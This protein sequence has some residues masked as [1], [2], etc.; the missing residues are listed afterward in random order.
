L[1]YKLRLCFKDRMGI[2]ADISTILASSGFNIVSMDVDRSK[3]ETHV[4]TEIENIELLIDQHGLFHIFD[5]IENFIEIQFIDTL[6]QEEKANRF[7]VVLDNMSDGVISID[8]DGTITTM[9]KV[10]AEVFMCNSEN[11][12]GQSIK[13]LNLPQYEI[14]KC[15]RGDKIDNI[16]QNLITANGRYQYLSTCKPIRDSSGR[17][18]GAVEIAKEMQEIKKLARSISLEMDAISFSDIIGENQAIK[19]AIAFAQKIAPTD[20]TVSIYGPSGTGKELFAKAIHTASNRKGLYIPVNCAA[21]PEQLLESELFGYVGGAFTG[22][23]KEGRAGLFEA[24]MDGTV[25]LDE[26]AEMPLGSQAKL[27]RLIQ[28]MAVRRIGDSKEIPINTRLITATNKNLD[29]LVRQNKFREDLYYRINVI[30]IHIPTLKERK[31][32]IPILL[33]HFL[34]EL[35]IRLG[36]KISSI[37]PLALQK[38]ISYDWPGNVRELKNVVERAAFFSNDTVIDVDAILFSHELTPYHGNYLNLHEGELGSLKCQVSEFEKKIVFEAL[39]KRKTVRKAA[40]ALK[41]SH[42]ALLKK[43]Q[44]YDIKLDRTVTTGSQMCQGANIQGN[45]K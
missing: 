14:L 36:K 24:A 32:D 37:T 4:Y 2:V 28:E 11:I 22:G 8:R 5:A 45:N 40:A 26:I 15:L 17:I 9:N 13:C 23:R 38:L 6:P 7:K 20:I 34:F 41:I 33:E 44:K 18:I 35:L 31:E 42:P 27:L 21:L 39:Q 19:E 10:A 29:Q 1:N 43:M 30:P 16:K 3:D 25:F 12:V